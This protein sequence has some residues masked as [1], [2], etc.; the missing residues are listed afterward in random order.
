MR[1]W[2]GEDAAVDGLSGL[3]YTDTLHLCVHICICERCTRSACLIECS[4]CAYSNALCITVHCDHGEGSKQ[5]LTAWVPAPTR[6]FCV[7]IYYVFVN[8]V[9]ALLVSLERSVS[10][11]FSVLCVTVYCA[12]GE[13]RKQLF[14]AWVDL[15]ACTRCFCAPS[16]LQCCG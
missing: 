2:G 5:L 6:H 13:E 3:G 1:V 12:Y 4:V 14:T 15:A 10:A 11:Q 9:H 7:F 16:G 8:A